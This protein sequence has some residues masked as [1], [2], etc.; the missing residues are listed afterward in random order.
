[1]NVSRRQFLVSA[2]AAAGTVLHG[3]Q[4]ARFVHTRGKDILTPAGNKLLLRGTNLGNWL[5]PEG[6][7]FLFEKGPVSPHE[8]EAFFDEL[9]GPDASNDFWQ[10]YRENYFSEGDIRFLARCGFNSV[11]VPLHYKYF[12]SD[13]GF[14]YLDPLIEWCRSAKLWVIL[15]MH[16]APGGQTGTNNDD[17]EGYPW[18]YESPQSQQLLIEV[19]KRIAQHYRDEPMVLGY[20]LLN[21]PIPHFPKLRKYN[22][23][24]EPLYKRVT[25]AIREVD[26]NH[27][28]ILGGAQWDS[29]FDVFGGPFD[30]NVIYQLHK[31]WT[32]PVRASIEPYIQ[33]R[34]KYKVPLWCGESGENEDKWVK[35]F[36][37]TLEENDI[38]WCFWPYKKM[39]KTSSPVSFAKPAHWDEIV[40]LAAMPGG[41]G[42]AEK[43]IAARPASEDL[44]R[45]MKELLENV[46]FEKCKVNKSYIE[47]LGLT[48]GR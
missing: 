47:A 32:P 38:G 25:G 2:A 27:T 17:S 21:E 35:E 14:K 6:Y 44:N 16:C 37:R 8:I 31:Y 19:W 43:R 33:F 42:N 45:A 3:A 18:L 9:I 41:T 4:T 22:S 40:A 36:V 12:V 13:A 26:A 46:R 24:L 48:A 11:R 34:D 39:V 5:E 15:D 1:M 23:A 20:D 28:I 30:S 7:M 29:N 10:R